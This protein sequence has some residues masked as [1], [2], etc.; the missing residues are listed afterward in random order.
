MNTSDETCAASLHSIS[1]PFFKHMINDSIKLSLLNEY[2]QV[3][4]NDSID[5]L[6]SFVECLHT[7]SRQDHTSTFDRTFVV[8]YVEL[9]HVF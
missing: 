3:N 7:Y 4:D 6:Y 1:L 9:F 8:M 2:E 5:I